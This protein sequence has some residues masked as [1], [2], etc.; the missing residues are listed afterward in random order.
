MEEELS[1]PVVLDYDD[2]IAVI[3][4]KVRVTYH[5]KNGELRELTGFLGLPHAL[6]PDLVYFVERE[7]D[8]D[9]P[10]VKCLIQKNIES[11]YQLET[12]LRVRISG[13]YYND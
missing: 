9:E 7:Y 8:S 1:K 6:R 2:L 10:E 5:K 3:Q 4:D 11:V 13:G 12:G